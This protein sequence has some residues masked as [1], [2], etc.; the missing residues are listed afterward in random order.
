MPCA[1]GLQM[2]AIWI[3]LNTMTDGYGLGILAE[4]L[5]E[6]LKFGGNAIAGSNKAPRP[7][8]SCQDRLAIIAWLAWMISKTVG[9]LVMRL[10]KG[11]C[12]SYS[13]H[14]FKSQRAG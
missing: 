6:G 1:A 3:V 7:S 10:R 14:Y 12:H 5:C 13:T 8:K 4:F 2:E 11:T 9:R